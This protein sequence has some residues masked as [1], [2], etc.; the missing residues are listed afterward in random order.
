MNTE[1]APALGDGDEGVEELGELRR[2]RGELVDDDD[3]A[4][5]RLTRGDPAISG[6][7]TRRGVTQDRFAAPQLRIQAGQDAPREAVVEVG[8]DPGHVRKIAHGIERASS[9]VVDEEERHRLRP[10][11]GG[12]GD[13]EGAQQLALARPRRPGDQ[14]VRPVAL[15]VELDD[16]VGGTPEDGD[17]PRAVPPCCP[18]GAD[19]SRGGGPRTEQLAESDRRGER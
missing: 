14:R 17:G 6:E 19:C 8:D 11:T 3:E 4:R 5:Q 12:E 16:P 10:G 15:Q 7:V 1:A 2:Q 18:P 9:L 13:D